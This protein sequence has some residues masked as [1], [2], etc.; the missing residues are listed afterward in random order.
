M[1]M[2]CSMRDCWANPQVMKTAV[3][4]EMTI[5]NLT[6]ARRRWRRPSFI[7][8]VHTHFM[9]TISTALFPLYYYQTV[10]HRSGGKF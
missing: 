4:K 8:L 2:N 9:V 1:Q 3:E 10:F 6:L 5:T 7:R